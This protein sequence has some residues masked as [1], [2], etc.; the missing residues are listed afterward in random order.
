MNLFSAK[1]RPAPPDHL[2]GNTR[3]RPRF[4]ALRVLVAMI[5]RE[6][7]TRFG[8]TWGGYIWAVV[9]PVAMIGLLS[10]AFSQFIKTPPIG[11]SFVL[12][13]ASGFV[14]FY[15]YS[16]ITTAT[17]SAVMFNKPLMQFP[18]VT[19]LDAVFARFFLSALTLTVVGVIVY[20][21]IGYFDAWPNGINF[22]AVLLSLAAACLLGLGSGTLNC[23]LFSFFPVWARIWGVIN[24]PLFLI[25]GVFF[26]LESMPEQIQAILWY[27]PLV[28]VVG[29]MRTGI[30]PSY[31]AGYVSL[32]FVFGLG[33]SCFVLGTYLLIR[34]RSYVTEN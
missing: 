10:L 2:S 28:H 16:E 32:L 1:S 20:I 31:D 8:R 34:H 21:G 22:G 19:P 7:N 30:Y 24:R 5:I 11:S 12:F 4:Q 18:A 17:S 25:S 6:M 23:V 14:P 33:I 26:T 15:F 13:Y 29:I 3:Y 27:N 9:E